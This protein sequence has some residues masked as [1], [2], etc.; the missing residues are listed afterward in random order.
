MAC[1]YRAMACP[2][3]DFYRPGLRDA[4]ERGHYDGG[5]SGP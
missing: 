3:G 5:A 1:P 2:Y 4:I